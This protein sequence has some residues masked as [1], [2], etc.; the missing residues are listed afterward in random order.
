MSKKIA[1]VGAGWMAAYHVAGFRG[2][3]AEVVAI[4]DKSP[5][6]AKAASQKY[7]VD[8]TFAEPKELFAA[9]K[10][11]DAVSIITPN[12]FHHPLVLEALAAG[13]HVFCEKPPA[14]N[15]ADVTQM[16][17]TAALVAALESKKL[18]GAGL[19]VTDPE[20]LPADHALWRMGNVI[21]T[22][23]VSGQSP[24]TRLRTRSLFIENMKR[25]AAG[26]PLINVVDKKAGY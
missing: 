15:A 6:A 11:V 7:S 25:F 17:D 16:V 20:P 13:K 19:D 12:V 23:H 24:G 5:A 9:I 10:D 3:G 22:P 2:A 8:K 18:Q 21:V 14:L 1:I 26:E 4:V